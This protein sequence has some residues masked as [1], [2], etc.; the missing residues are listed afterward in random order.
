MRTIESDIFRCFLTWLTEM[1]YTAIFMSSSDIIDFVFLILLTNIII[2]CHH[3]MKKPVLFF[4]CSFQSH[5]IP[6]HC[7]LVQMFSSNF[8]IF[9]VQCVFIIKQL[10]NHVKKQLSPPLEAH[11]S[12][13][14]HWLGMKSYSCL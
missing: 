4:H 9:S 7:L 6:H 8:G 2:E 11:I 3:P 13:L 12:V 14:K 5:Y 1:N 10:V